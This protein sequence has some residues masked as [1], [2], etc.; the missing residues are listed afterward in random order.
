MEH[1]HEPYI[2]LDNIVRC[3]T[4]GEILPYAE[5]EL[6]KVSSARIAN[7]ILDEMAIKGGLQVGAF[8]ENF[9]VYFKEK[10]GIREEVTAKKKSDR[11]YVVLQRFISKGE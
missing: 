6:A 9:I 7:R 4:C 8:E 3:R 1:K 10:D 11:V 2:S 5:I